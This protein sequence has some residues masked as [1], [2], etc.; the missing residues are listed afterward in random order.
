MTGATANPISGNNFLI[1]KC[2]GV[3][4]CRESSPHKM[5]GAP[6]K[7]R[8]SLTGAPCHAMRSRAALILQAVGR[9][10]D[11]NAASVGHVRIDHRRSNIGVPKEF[12]DGADVRARLEQVGRK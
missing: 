3:V 11:A 7:S 2:R 8:A 6:Q 9:A 10:A 5:W 4:I 1:V 12:L